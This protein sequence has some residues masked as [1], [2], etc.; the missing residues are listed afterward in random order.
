MADV[1]LNAFSFEG[2]TLNLTR[3]CVRNANGEIELRPKSFELLSY[4]VA[5]AGRLVSKDELVNAVW[6]DVIVSDDS[7][8]QCVSDVRRALNDAERRIIKTV[9]RRGYLFAAP[10]SVAPGHPA[11]GQRFAGFSDGA[12]QDY[13]V[14][15]GL[16]LDPSASSQQGH[17][18]E[19]RRLA[20][21]LAADVVGYSRL[22]GADEGST[23]RALKAIRAELFDPAIAA[24]NGRLV[25]TTGDGLLVEFGSVVDALRCATQF[26]ERNAEYNKRLPADKRIEFRVGVHQGDIVVE[27]GDIFGDGVNIAVRLEG[28]AQSGGICVSARV[29]EDA[30]GKLDLM[31]EDLGEQQLKNISRPVRVYRV[32]STGARTWAEPRAVTAPRLSIVVL[33]FAN[34]SNDPGQQYFA[35][36]ITDDLTLIC[37]GFPEAL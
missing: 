1:G 18:R 5:N 30:V 11:L 12:D 6:P 17:A 7:L 16:S 27:D 14:G 3:G 28:L 29:Q 21:I 15:D 33:P 8:A 24:H 22:I 34:L 20:A 32:L 31:F 26:Q 35:D 10:V 4:L 9:P 13:S 23:L 37:Q 25:K 2:Y 36:G 19:T